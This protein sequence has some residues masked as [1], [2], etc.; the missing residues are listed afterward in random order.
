MTEKI[1]KAS[2]YFNSGLYCSQ[3]VLGTFCENYNM[4]TKTA[5]KISCGLNSGSRCD[6]I[7]G[8]VS[9]AILVIGL[10]YGDSADVCNLKTEEFIRAFKNKNG[11]VI[12]RNILGC[13]I[14]TPMGKEKAINENLFKTTCLDMVISAAQILEDLGY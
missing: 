9:G 8:A 11:N 12:C 4:D 13:D 6:E 7:C 3:S 5:F 10:K 2:D 1:K 14:S